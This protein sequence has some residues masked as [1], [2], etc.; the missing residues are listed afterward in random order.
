MPT[1]AAVR[2]T[3]D[4]WLAARWPVVTARQDAYFANHGRYWQGLRTHLAIP[5][6]TNST[7]GSA[8][9]DRLAEHPTD[10]ASSWLDVLAEW[11]G[12]PIAAAVVMAAY[13][14]PLGHGYVGTVIL[15]HN[16][17]TYLRRQNVGPESYRT[18]AWR[19]LD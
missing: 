11:S 10:Q 7:D 18:E 17:T 15:L 5:S 12:V 1:L 8:V 6:H 16:G 14:G 2:T 13:E 3:V 4:N 9:A 19:I